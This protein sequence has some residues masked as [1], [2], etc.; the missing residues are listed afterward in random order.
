VVTLLLLSTYAAIAAVG[1][2]VRAGLASRAE[3]LLCAFLTWNA[4]ILVP[5]HLLGV[6]GALTAGK[7]V[8]ASIATSTLCIV[9]SFY[10]ASSPGAHTR[11]IAQLSAR[12]ARAPW[13]A[14]VL[15]T[16]ARSLVLAGVLGVALVVAW[17]TWLSYLLPSDSWDGLLYHDGMVGY[18][19]Q[20]Q[21]YAPTDLPRHLAFGVRAGII[22]QI[23]GF[24]RNCEMTALWF[25]IFWDRRLIEVTN[26]LMLVPLALATYCLAM[27][28]SNDRVLAMGWATAA[29]LTPAAA[30]ELRSTYI[31]VQ[32]TAFFL[33]AVH[34]VTR[35][36]MRLRD[37]WIASLCLALL[38]GGKSLGLVWVPAMSVVAVA[39][40]VWQTGRARPSATA[41]T[42]AG[43][44]AL[45]LAFASVT[46]L[47]NWLNFGDPIWPMTYDRAWPSIHWHGLARLEEFGENMSAAETLSAVTSARPFGSE[48]PDTGTWAW[49]W[50]LVF[51]VLP[52]AAVAAAVLVTSVARAGATR[53]LSSA[54]ITDR[55]R[56]DNNLAIVWLLFFMSAVSVHILWHPRYNLHLVAGL[57]LLVHWLSRNARRLGE[58][59]VIFCILSNVLYLWWAAPGW[60]AGFDQ[61]R[62]YFKMTATERA[63]RATAGWAMEPEVAL[64]RERELG[65]SSVT[66]FTDDLLFPSLLWNEKFTNR[67]AYVPHV[68]PA[69][70]VAQA[71]A[72]GADWIVVGPGDL[73][74]ALAAQRGR[75]VSIGIA[76]KAGAIRAYR[77]VSAGAS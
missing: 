31:D 52:L 11:A 23:D 58:G 72:K 56:E 65:P 66:V 13:D 73:D 48:F 10:R 12:M 76:S 51:L 57:M 8:L 61:A 41:A 30:L 4:I 3:S 70:F 17:T 64:A 16:R 47:R 40:L 20:N 2:T 29:A 37:G 59:A 77:R 27:R 25:T 24:P 63:T 55:E 5:I 68:A 54:S 75:W 33:A 42:C 69:D 26:S 19:I 22:Q 32:V 50:G 28:Y 53:L 35:P 45:I 38:M 43:G 9:A 36:T 71:E 67:I 46:Y 44:A 6:S 7:L 18:A 49:G 15:C 39:R 62:Q 34:F 74:A 60:G 21:G 1:V 14:V